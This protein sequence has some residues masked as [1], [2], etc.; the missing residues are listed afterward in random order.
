MGASEIINS[1]SRV[2]DRRKHF[3]LPLAT[4]ALLAVVAWDKFVAPVAAEAHQQNKDDHQKIIEFGPKIVGCE[5]GIETLTMTVGALA[6]H[7]AEDERNNAA[8]VVELRSI[9]QEIKTGFEGINIRANELNLHETELN[10]ATNRRID[11][12]VSRMPHGGP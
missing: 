12:V 6:T 8:V 3:A 10:S 5:K 9:H 4:V 7:Q 11:D 2:T 1:F